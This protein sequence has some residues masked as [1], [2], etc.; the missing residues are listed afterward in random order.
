MAKKTR[1]RTVTKK[2]KP[3]V[4]EEVAVVENELEEENDVI[5]DEEEYEEEEVEKPE[6]VKGKYKKQGAGTIC[7]RGVYYSEGN[8]L[9]IN[10]ASEIPKAFKDVIV[11][12]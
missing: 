1:K 10:K 3:E 4:E 7:F 5:D 12:V 11:K 9:P 8:I 2:A 6:P